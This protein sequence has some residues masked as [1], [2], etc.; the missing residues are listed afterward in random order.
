MTSSRDDSAVLIVAVVVIL[1][2]LAGGVLFIARRA[3]SLRALA[4]AQQAQALQME[5]RVRA[6]T[7]RA[8]EDARR[9]GE[10]AAN[11]DAGSAPAGA[12]KPA[13]QSS[14]LRQAL[15]RAAAKLDQGS[16]TDPSAAAS[17]HA[18][19]GQGYLGLG[20]LDS[21]E[22]HFLAALALHAKVSGEESPEAAADRE[23]LA[24]VAAARAK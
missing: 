23:G 8:E 22:R 6:E 24:K 21:A 5:A 15:D 18:A 17:M 13:D 12:A 3:A 2:L 14:A 19:L 11:P 7:A 10:T 20:D 1:T 9:A 4:S 16:V